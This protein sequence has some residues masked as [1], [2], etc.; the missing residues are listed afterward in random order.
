MRAEGRDALE[1]VLAVINTSQA[2]LRELRDEVRGAQEDTAVK[3]A[4]LRSERAFQFRKK[5]HKE[6]YSFNAAVRGRIVEA[7]L[8]L[9]GDGAKC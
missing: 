5:G 2:E 8:Q 4:T 6:Q 7:G 9:D 3:L 1:L